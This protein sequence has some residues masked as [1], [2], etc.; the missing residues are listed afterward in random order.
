MLNIQGM[1]CSINS[2]SYWKL[3]FLIEQLGLDSD[4]ESV[5]VP[6]IAICES[7]LKSRHTDTQVN[8][9]NY[10]TLRADRSD[11]R[12]RGGSLLYVH[13]KLPTRDMSCFDD[14]ICEAVICNVVSTKTLV[15][16]IYR[17]PNAPIE[18]FSNMLKF[19][20]TYINKETEEQHMNILILGDFNLPCLRWTDETVP[21]QYQYLNIESADIL[22]SFINTN[23]LSQYVDK[24]TRQQNILDLVLSNQPNMIK[25][26]EVED[27]KLSDHRLIRVKTNFGLKPPNSIRRHIEPHT[28]R[29]LNFY[30]A[31]FDEINHHIGSVNWDELNELC[32]PDEFPELVRLT[33]LQICELYTPVKCCRS[34]KLSKYKRER[35]SL[36]RK[37]RK[38]NLRLLNK[39]IN[40]SVK[41]NTKRKLVKIHDQI[42]LSINDE[43]MKNEKEAV[44]KIQ[45]DPKYFYN[46]SSQ[47][48]KCKSGIG[49]LLHEGS[50]HYDDKSMSDIL[51]KQFCSVFSD[52]E[53]PSK[54]L[55]DI[56]AEYDKPLTEIKITLEDIDRALKEI[57]PH[58]STTND[59]MPA[60][61][62]KKC[63]TT[64]NYPLLLIWSH[65][66]ENGLV[67]P[68][69]KEQIIT[70]L[71]KKESRAVAENYRPICPTS[72]SSK[73]CERVVRDKIIDHL[74]RNNLLCKHQH[75]FRPG[76]SC[77]T[78]LLNHINIVILNFIN[79]T[80]TDCIYLDYAKAFDKVDHELLIHKLK[81]YGIQGSLLEWIKSF[82]N[83]RYQTVSV[84]GTHSYKSKVK[85]GVPQG[86]VLGP[87]LFLVYI[88][89]IDQCIKHSFISCFADDTRVSKGISMS[90][91]VQYLQE[92]LNSVMQWTSKNN[93]LLH[94]K[95][96]QY[97]NHNTGDTKL[98]KELPFTSEFYHYRTS[99][100]TILAPIDSVRDLGIKVTSN[101]SWSP[102]IRNIVDDA[103]RMA[104]WILS[105]FSTRDSEVMLTL[106]KSLVRPRVEYCCPL[107][108]PKKIGDIIHLEQVQRQFTARIKDHQ[109][110]TYHQRLRALKLMS[111]QRRRER[112]SILHLHKI[113][114]NMVTSDLNITTNYSARRGLSIT[115]PPINKHTKARFQTMR[116]GFFTVAA[117]K[118]FN[119]LP[120]HIRDEDKFGPFKS[121][122]TAY[123][124]SIPDCPPISGESSSNSVLQ[125]A[126]WMEDIL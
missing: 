123:L 115:I 24:P 109:Q 95:K 81:C 27:T 63:S 5:Y 16:S 87:L 37:K 101:L 73:T 1:D 49:P 97:V 100:G 107:W 74:I 14:N 39:E 76:H 15:A 83:E 25:H 2:T 91:D 3:P 110:L 53:N 119:S 33:I 94:E 38:L 7:W 92:D 32:T 8:I 22:M 31:Q 108:D 23:F 56:E 46:Y 40:E 96:F 34:K 120:K 17:P 36:G 111:L 60:L 90:N 62:M 30:K 44:N 79:N 124:L 89:D 13:N 28:Y 55:Y 112:Y 66:L 67:Y 71:H 106:F 41:T 103:N 113:V 6:F 105:I 114:H 9:P 35:R 52:P 54:E 45:T 50:L 20:Q 65:S 29:S 98:L 59:D 102:H 86:T 51:Q 43:Y 61:L 48:M 26:I 70:P 21:P 69:Y 85:S 42:K 77:L 64:I 99:N 4:D 118:L 93:M 78:Q 47:R 57:K 117:P 88:N 84:N 19:L 82:L 12:L 72:H 68:Q 122:L 11:D 80:D 75:G 121:K 125:Y 58:S 10:Q 104:A 126:G 18:S 116:D